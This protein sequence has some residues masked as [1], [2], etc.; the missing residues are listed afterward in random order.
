VLEALDLV[1]G[2]DRLSRQSPID[3]HDFYQGKYFVSDDSS[4]D[5][6]A[7]SAEEPRIIITATITA[8]S[9]EQL[10]YFGSYIEWWDASSY[11][12]FD[13]PNAA[14]LDA[15]PT[16]PALRITFIGR[17][18]QD[19]DDFEGKTYYT[20]T[21][22]EADEP[23]QFGKRDKQ[24]CGFLYLRSIRTGSRALS[25]ER[26]SLLDIILRLKEIRPK[27]WEATLSGLLTFDVA[28]NPELGVSGVLGSIDAALKKYVPSEWGIQ[29]HL[30]VSALTRRHLREVITAF[31]ATGDGAHSAPYYRQ[32][33]GT[34]NMLLLAMLSQI[35]EDKQNVIF[36]MEEP[37]TAIPPYAQKRIVH[38]L[39]N[40][41]AQSLV[42]SHS[43]YVLEEFSLEETLV[44]S[45]SSAGELVSA[46]IVLP[47][48]VKHKRY[49]QEFRSRFCE[50]LLA[51]RILVVEGATEA[52][53]VPA[54]A[55]RLAELNPST[56]VSLESLGVSVLDAGSDSQI[57]DLA[58]LYKNLGKDTFAFCD[59]QSPGQEAKI[60]GAV[61]MLFMHNENDFE[62]LVL[63]NTTQAALERFA[64]GLE[65]PPHLKT[66][67]PDLKKNTSAALTDYFNWSKG[68]WGMADYLTQC[69]EA[70]IPKWLRDVCLAL[71]V[72]C[73]PP[74]AAPPPAPAT[75]PKKA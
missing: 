48:S 54:V 37:E 60:L 32:G 51:R 24:R 57:F 20:R 58:T 10:A 50:S 3:E 23:D 64:N 18:D 41:A 17:Y 16:I 47:D 44:L 7:P 66:K 75:K 14:K 2:P 30:R 56:Y 73:L 39:R 19:E 59:K 49:R 61:K 67:Y 45:R 70:E 21:L 1:L 22:V 28:S 12:L 55:R 63:K 72:Q 6:K 69:N 9:D 8:L 36:A 38:E 62:D 74:A 13:E 42:T 27:M 11:K 26:G 52:A 33:T 4:G 35:A 34:V 40:L 68:N 29:P 31:I 15:A 25:L 65:W 53:A 46:K 5:T 43:P 71:K